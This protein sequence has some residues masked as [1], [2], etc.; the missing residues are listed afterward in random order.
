MLGRPA[1]E[2]VN[3][4]ARGIA[5]RE[6]RTAWIQGATNSRENPVACVQTQAA[7]VD[8]G[9]RKLVITIGRAETHDA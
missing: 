1:A 7:R 6:T 3:S 2:E 8:R 4:R 5:R 9:T